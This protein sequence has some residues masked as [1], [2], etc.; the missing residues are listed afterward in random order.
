MGF[1][2][3]Y[4]VVLLSSRC[5]DCSRGRSVVNAGGA[6]FGCKIS[7]GGAT[8]GILSGVLFFLF[9]ATYEIESLTYFF[10]SFFFFFFFF[11]FLRILIFV[12]SSRGSFN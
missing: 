11:F 3:E 9:I 2:R 7:E 1:L 10:P 8:S 12:F 6:Q 4:S 5:W